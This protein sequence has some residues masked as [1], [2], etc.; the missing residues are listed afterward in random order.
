MIAKQ[1]VNRIISRDR[2][3]IGSAKKITVIVEQRGKS[4]KYFIAYSPEIPGL[5]TRARKATKA[6]NRF[7]LVTL[8]CWLNE[9]VENLVFEKQKEIRLWLQDDEIAIKPKRAKKEDHDIIQASVNF[10]QL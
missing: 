1:T 2:Y 10:F 9:Y 5:A 8:D 6:H 4:G 3:T 7:M